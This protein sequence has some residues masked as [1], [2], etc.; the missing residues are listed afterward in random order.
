MYFIFFVVK[1][2]P[3]ETSCTL[4]DTFP[5]MEGRRAVGG[6]VEVIIKCMPEVKLILRSKVQ[7]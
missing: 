1:L 6:K 3:L 2:S 7:C 5:L 4:H